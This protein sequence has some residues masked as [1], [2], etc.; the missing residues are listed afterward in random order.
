MQENSKIPTIPAIF[1]IITLTGH[2]NL[3]VKVSFLCY[4][5]DIVPS[6]I[7]CEDVTKYGNYMY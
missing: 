2:G 7:V 5:V 3:E 4:Q 6:K 1:Y